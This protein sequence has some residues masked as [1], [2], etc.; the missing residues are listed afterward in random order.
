MSNDIKELKTLIEDIKNNIYAHETWIGKATNDNDCKKWTEE[1]E[2]LK[3]E[4]SELE[5]ELEAKTKH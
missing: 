2:Q 1:L 4:L 3:A 5:E